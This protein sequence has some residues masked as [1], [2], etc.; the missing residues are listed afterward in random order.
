MRKLVAAILGLFVAVG[1]AHGA[2]DAAA[3]KEKVASCQGCHGE[4]GNSTNPE[5]PK[6]AGQHAEYIAKQLGD[7][8]TG[9]RK[10]PTMTAMAAS[11]SATDMADLG[12]YFSGQDIKVGTVD[13]G[14]ARRG[15]R[16][17]RG[18]NPVS[19]VPACIG[20][21]GPSGNGNPTAKFPALGGQHKAYIEKTLKDFKYGTRANDLNEMMRDIA[22]KMS[23]GEI[24][25][26][27][28]YIS[29]L[30]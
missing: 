14:L 24:S 30:H 6:L 18:G 8:K 11:L 9:A 4:D 7:F 2:G 29:G 3:G 13:G 1:A 23:D 27:A 25:V 15:E 17:Y 21:H 16:I 5:W 20:C 26:V 22:V 10:D 12:A 28:E 19:G